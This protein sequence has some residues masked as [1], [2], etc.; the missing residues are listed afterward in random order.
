MERKTRI[1]RKR[2]GETTLVPLIRED[3]QDRYLQF[4]DLQD[5]TKTAFEKVLE[6]PQSQELNKAV[7]FAQRDE[8]MFGFNFWIDIREHYGNWVDPLA[9]RDGFELVIQKKQPDI[10]KDILNGGIQP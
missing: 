8:M 9:I 3:F 10:L 1:S 6:D 2:H 4:V 7:T 5:A